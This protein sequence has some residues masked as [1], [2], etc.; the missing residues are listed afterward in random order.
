M[1]KILF[2]SLGFACSLLPTLGCDGSNVGP[3]DEFLYWS[4]FEAD[5]DTVGWR[6]VGTMTFRNEAPLGGGRR[7]ICVS[8]GCPIPHAVFEMEPSSEDR[9]LVLRCWGKGEGTGGVVALGGRGPNDPLGQ[10]GVRIR[11]SKWAPYR[12]EILFWPANE[13]LTLEIRGGGM[14]FGAALIDLLEVCVVE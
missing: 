10:I 4:S 1:K 12:S 6:G 11:E 8:G 9:R 14:S 3:D 13:P 5:A 2:I 7:A